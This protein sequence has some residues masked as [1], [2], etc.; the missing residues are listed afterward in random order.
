MSAPAEL[1]P[2]PYRVVDEKGQGWHGSYT[3]VLNPDYTG[4]DP[5]FRTPERVEPPKYIDVEPT[6]YT[7]DYGKSRNL[8]PRTLEELK[9][10][11]GP[12]LRV[13]TSP[14]EES[15]R[16]LKDALRSAGRKA[17]CTVVVALWHAQQQTSHLPSPSGYLLIAGREGSWESEGL[18]G[19]VWWGHE[20][21][22]KPKRYDSAAAD[23]DRRGARG[24]GDRA[25]PLRGSRRDAG[26]HV[27]PGRRRG[28]A[29]RR[30]RT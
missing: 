17:A 26:L 13:V 1:P 9:A 14:S 28:R 16:E 7:A 4:E 27:R 8:E 25:R 11:R 29:R 21:E 19:L 12:T 18:K 15:V 22:V 3:R 24:V 5:Q 23:R 2:I 30:P 10:T 20:L 6:C